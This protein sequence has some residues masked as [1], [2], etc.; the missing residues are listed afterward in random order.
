MGK[1]DSKKFL[2]LLELNSKPILGNLWFQRRTNEVLILSKEEKRLILLKISILYVT[3]GDMMKL[4][5]RQR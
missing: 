5:S 4:K 1:F 2:R 3:F